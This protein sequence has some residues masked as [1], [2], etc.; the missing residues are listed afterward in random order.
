MI[1]ETRFEKTRRIEALRIT[2]GGHTIKRVYW[3]ELV[4]Y[5]KI[6]ELYEFFKVRITFK[7]VLRFD[8]SRKDEGKRRIS[9]VRRARQAVF[10]L[11]E[12]NVRE[13]GDYRPIFFT[14]TFKEN[15][16][17]L[18]KANRFFKE[19]IRKLNRI[20]PSRIRYVIVP[21][22]QDRGAI[23]YHGVFFNLPFI[24]IKKFEK[25]WGHGFIDIQV[26]R[27]I[28]STGAYLAKYL[29]K[30]YFDERLYGEK[31]FFCSRGLIRPIHIYEDSEIDRIL[32]NAII[33]ESNYYQRSNCK[34]SK[35]VCK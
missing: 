32:N 5:G 19:F 35:F 3:R 13:H 31:A 14:L 2:R 24:D 27:R 30:E 34:F 25:L 11:V 4:E 23:H 8:Y 1:T 16:E 15:I 18:R 9:S 17:N 6:F 12:A 28:R 26:S 21:E 33:K 10:R 7:E 29:T 20:V 22:F